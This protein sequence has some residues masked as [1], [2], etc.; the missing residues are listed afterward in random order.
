MKKGQV[1][2]IDWS[3][4]LGLFLISTLTAVMFLNNTNMAPDQTNSLESKALEI[5]AQLESRT[6]IQA[7]KIPLISKGSVK[8]SNI[9]IDR[10]YN[11][12]SDAYPYSGGGNIPAQ[13]DIEKK[14]T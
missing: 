1:I 7:Y 3:V 5:Q 6:G 2:N 9:P 14:T 4:G 8:V 13:L 12:K 10:T 11:F